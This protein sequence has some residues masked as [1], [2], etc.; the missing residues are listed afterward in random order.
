[1]GIGLENTG[2]SWAMNLQP[3]CRSRVGYRK[4]TATGQK[5]DDV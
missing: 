5:I 2:N 3:V 4:D 1:V